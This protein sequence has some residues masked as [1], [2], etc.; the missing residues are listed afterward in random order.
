MSGKP[1]LMTNAAELDIRWWKG[2]EFIVLKGE[3]R[4]LGISF[5]GVVAFEFFRFD[6]GKIFNNKGSL[7]RNHFNPTLC[8]EFVKSCKNRLSM[9]FQS[10]ASGR[11]PGSFSPRLNLPWRML[12]IIVLATCKYTGTSDDLSMTISCFNGS[13]GL[14]V[15]TI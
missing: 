12:I 4:S 7:A 10:A 6:V 5:D 14:L 3:S 15:F 9:N 2:G 1:S 8:H 13:I 11:D